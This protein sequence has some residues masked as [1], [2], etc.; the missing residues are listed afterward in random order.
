[1][2]F[3]S[4]NGQGEILLHR[5]LWGMSLCN[6]IFVTLSTGHHD[7]E[8]K[9]NWTSG[10]NMRAS[11]TSFTTPTC[12]N[13]PFS[14]SLF[15]NW[16]QN[17]EECAADAAITFL[18]QECGTANDFP[19]TLFT[20]VLSYSLPLRE[21]CNKHNKVHWCKMLSGSW[22]TMK[23]SLLKKVLLEMGPPHQ[24]FSSVP[25]LPSWITWMVGR[26]RE[27]SVSARDLQ[28]RPA[29]VTVWS[30]PQPLCDN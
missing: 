7:R 14:F 25:G 2:S 4:G 11:R 16:W 8:W 26:V 27:A 1:M 17:N 5:F 21:C 9:I 12:Y 6:T 24:F 23:Q 3:I 28:C 22:Y 18:N 29:G 20:R 13:L 10:H 30:V 15:E 19:A